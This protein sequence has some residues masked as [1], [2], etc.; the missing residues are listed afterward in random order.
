MDALRDGV[1]LRAQG[2]KDPLVEYKVEAYK[3]FETLMESIKSDALGNLFRSTSSLDHFE[4]FL[5]S[6]PAEYSD[7]ETSEQPITNRN[8]GQAVSTQGGIPLRDN[9][10]IKIELPKRKFMQINSPR[11][12]D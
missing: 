11:N 1:S 4:N 6:M 3:L 7:N 10:K 5:R 2:Q 8:I 9:K 12:S